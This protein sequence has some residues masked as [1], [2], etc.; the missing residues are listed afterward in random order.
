M[1]RTTGV[2]NPIL[3]PS[4]RLLVS[5]SAQ[6]SA[7]T[8]GVPSDLYAFHRSTGNSL[9]PYHALRPII[10]DKAC[11]LCL[12]AAAGTELADA[13]F[14]DTESGPCLSPSVADHPLGPATDHRLG[15]LLPHQLSNQMQAPPWVDC[16]F[17][18]STYRS[19][20]KNDLSVNL[21]NITPK[22]PNYVLRKVDRV[23]LTSGFEI[24]A[25][26]LG[27]GH[28]LQEHSLVLVRGGRVKDLPGVRYHIVIGTLDAA[29]VKDHRQGRSKY[30]TKKPK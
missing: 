14:P 7:F 28:N 30:G 6:Q 22:K 1:A 12:T 23:R 18:S 3:S 17:R 29:A 15:K 10:L 13:Y 25:Y 4:F 2:S 20:S 9:C 16:S 11:I 24:I 8:I 5:V 26:I 19:G 27:I 21:S